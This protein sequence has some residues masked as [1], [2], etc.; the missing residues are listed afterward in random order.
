MSDLQK[1]LDKMPTYC[2]VTYARGD[3][4][5]PEELD[6][7]GMP[8]FKRLVVG[9]N[10]SEAGFGFGEIVIVVD[11]A[12]GKHYIDAETMSR[13][14]VKAL[15]GLMVDNAILDTDPDYKPPAL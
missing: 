10:F 7:I 13:E 11:P 2:A 14:H 12:T 3:K 1:I 4:I 8:K 15:L 5:E 9:F 6:E